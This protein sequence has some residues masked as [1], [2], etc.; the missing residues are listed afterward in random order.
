MD[1]TPKL[2]DGFIASPKV[3]I[4]KGKRVGVQSM[5]CNISGVEGRARAWGWGLGR[6]TSNSI[7]HTN[8]HKPNNKLVSA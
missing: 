4:A 3:K 6:L 8:L 1:D 7:I 5:A 2:L